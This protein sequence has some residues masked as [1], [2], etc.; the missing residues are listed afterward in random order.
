ML[1]IAYNIDKCFK[2]VSKRENKMPV[3]V[4]LNEHSKLV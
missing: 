1:L 3:I 2:K 4:I